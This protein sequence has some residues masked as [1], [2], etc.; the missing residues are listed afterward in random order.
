VIYHTMCV[1]VC[2]CVFVYVCVYT[3]THGDI[4]GLRPGVGAYMDRCPIVLDRRPIVL[5]IY[6]QTSHSIGHI[7]T[8][9]P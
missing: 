7:W 5:G 2:V 4:P 9:V 1:R 8:D 6:G 3:H